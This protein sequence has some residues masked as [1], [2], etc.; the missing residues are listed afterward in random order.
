[1]E[2]LFR[3]AQLLRQI[4]VLRAQVDAEANACKPE[5]CK[6]SLLSLAGGSAPGR[7]ALENVMGYYT[8][9]NIVLSDTACLVSTAATQ[10]TIAP[11]AFQYTNTL[12]CQMQEKQIEVHGIQAENSTRRW[13]FVPD[14]V[15]AI[16]Y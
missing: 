8:A 9:D 2:K 11:P 4:P 1:M 14:G 10:Q 3:V 13:Y 16:W 5:Q 15:C 12:D 6:K 7:D